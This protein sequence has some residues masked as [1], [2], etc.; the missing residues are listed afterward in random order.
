MGRTSAVAKTN[1]PQPQAHS[2]EVGRLNG[3]QALLRGPRTLEAE[4]DGA[5]LGWPRPAPV[6]SVLPLP[7]R[8]GW[9]RVCKRVGDLG[10]AVTLLLV[11]APLLLFVAV[12]VKLTSRGPVLYSQVRVGRNGR[13]FT[14]YKIRTMMHRCESLTGA[15]WSVPGDPRI[16]PLGRW[17]RR[18]HLDE[19]PQLWNVLRGEMSL[20]GPRPERP[21]FVPQLAQALPRYTDRLLVRPGLTGLAQLQLPPDTDL[22]SVALKLT[23]D[24]YYVRRV[25]MWLDVR[26]LAGTALKVIG[27]P[28]TGLRRILH[29]P[30]REA[31]VRSYRASL[32]PRK[33]NS[34]ALLCQD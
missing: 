15:Q 33:G 18:S 2:A 7:G 1:F 3:S 34:L 13:P 6:R 5:C 27:V 23:Y 17:L 4:S 8:E 9:C 20:V 28:F 11:T 31:I 30:R 10:I 14:L 19:L 16:T 12:L 25:G 29:L 26:L 22:D 24:L 32:P 21:E